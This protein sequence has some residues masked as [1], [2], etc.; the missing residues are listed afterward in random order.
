MTIANVLYITGGRTNVEIYGIKNDKYM[1]LWEGQVDD[2][3]FPVVPY[4]NYKVQHMTVINEE[5]V[6][7]LHFDYPELTEEQKDIVNREAVGY[8][9]PTDWIEQLYIKYCDWDKVKNIL[10]SKTNDEIY[11]EIKIIPNDITVEDDNKIEKED[12][13][14][15]NPWSSGLQGHGI[16]IMIESGD[17]NRIIYKGS[18]E[19]DEFAKC[20]TAQ[21]SC[22]IFTEIE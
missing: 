14:T 20:I 1:K 9:Y 22:N 6:L 10:L 21:V 5:D 3:D 19:L 4:G 7:Q 15:I 13:I 8:P 18:M 11:E 16:D 12:K 2:I 17:E